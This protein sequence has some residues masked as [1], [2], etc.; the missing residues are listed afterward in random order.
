MSHV[1]ARCEV[2]GARHASVVSLTV[3]SIGTQQVGTA[4]SAEDTAQKTS[5]LAP[6]TSHHRDGMVYLLALVVVLVVSSVAV[7]MASGAG[8][9]LRAQDDLIGRA[10]AR[11]AALGMLRAVCNDLATAQVAGSLPQLIT[12]KPT[13]EKIG[14]CTVVLLGRDPSGLRAR[15]GLVS[16]AGK[17]SL[18][19]LIDPTVL[20]RGRLREALSAQSG[21][22]TEITAAICDWADADDNPD[23]D[24]GAERTDTHY[25]GAAVPYAPR[26]GKFETIDE[27]RLVRGVTDAVFFGEDTNGNGRLDPGEDTNGNGKLDL[28]LRDLVTL[29]NREPATAPDGS[30]LTDI[31]NG[32]ERTRRLVDLFGPERG[33]E[34]VLEAQQGQANGPY[35]NRLHFLKALDLTEAEAATL[36]TSLSG[37]ERRVGL[38]DAWACSEQ[39]LV[40]LVGVDLA[41]RIITARPATLPNGPGWLI[42]ALQPAEAITAGMVLTAGGYQF[43]AD[44]LAVSRNGWSRLDALIDCST[45]FPTVT[46]LRCS[47]AAG[48]PLPWASPATLRRAG[49]NDDL[50]T[51]LTSDRN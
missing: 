19:S 29:E 46:H 50:S 39:L 21:M 43:R 34:L 1:S 49:A 41:N 12:V 3:L 42:E 18:N 14:D 37:P 36:W 7:V 6:R 4:V 5:H 45:G 33:Q 47:D 13:G 22:T 28:G 9:R 20:Q 15:F 31:R 40:G 44:V 11:H 2:R 48:W 38:V 24:G 17:V 8:L 35:A 23:E 10:Q 26:N 30:P 16:E 32:G 27:L 51:L 25:Q